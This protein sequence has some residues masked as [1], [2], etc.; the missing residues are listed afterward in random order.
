MN[1]TKNQIV[2]IGGIGIV[3]L[4]FAL[5]FAGV[6]PGLRPG[7][8]VVANADLII[9]GLDS[10]KSIDPAIAA[11][12]AK[13]KGLTIE[14]REFTDE[15]EYNATLL[16][17]LAAGTGPD[18]FV[19]RNTGV[20]EHANKIA[21]L[22]AQNLPILSFRRLF[23]QV[24]ERDFVMNNSIY[25][26]PT[27]VDTL[28]LIY[29]KDTMN[30]A[31][32]ITPPG[33]WD[34][35]LALVPK[36]TTVDSARRI[37]RAGAAI[38]GSTQNIDT[39]ADVLSLLMLQNSVPMVDANLRSANFSTPGGSEALSFYTQF[40]NTGSNAYTWNAGLPRAL[41]L[42]SQGRLAMLFGY[43]SALSELRARNP[44][45]N[46]DVAPMPQ[47]AGTTQPVTYASYWGYTVARQSTNQDLAWNFIL[48]LTTENTPASAY[49]IETRRVPALLSLLN[50]Y[51]TDP[52]LNVFA[53]QALI[54]RSWPQVSPLA[55]TGIFSDMIDLVNENRA[56]ATEAVKLGEGR[57]SQLMSKRP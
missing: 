35:F 28:A 18:V 5:M 39:A 12:S 40:A 3:V 1:V 27:S 26:L 37:E 7:P 49:A 2:I 54:A 23:P 57:V 56:S 41:D 34:E 38:G 14:Y 19:V 11:F 17:S 42:M 25:A 21:P 50:T 46:L 32:I 47:R 55:I 16:D 29:N 33:T 48:T 30:Q 31:A 44:L 52:T 45:L 20:L 51:L 9:W 15:A 6:I 10:K 53:R 36:L 43:S 22:S 4:L 13:Y 8:E 24:V